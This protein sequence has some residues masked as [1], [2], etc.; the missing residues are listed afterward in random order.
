MQHA[1][2]YRHGLVSV[3][4]EH[5]LNMPSYRKSTINQMCTINWMSAWVTNLEE[6]CDSTLVLLHVLH[7]EALMEVARVGS[8]HCCGQCHVQPKM[9]HQVS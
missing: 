3:T 6:L 7:V 8:Y 1:V 9:P 4:D 5:A 2:L